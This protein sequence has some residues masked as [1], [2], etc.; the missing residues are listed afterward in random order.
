MPLRLYYQSHTEPQIPDSKHIHVVFR[1][2]IVRVSFVAAAG[3]V[4]ARV[5]TLAHSAGVVVS[6]GDATR[7][8]A[9]TSFP[10]A[11]A[12]FVAVIVATEALRELELGEVLVRVLF[13]LNRL[14]RS[15]R[16]VLFAFNT[17]FLSQPDRFS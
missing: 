10:P 11:P 6:R 5:A 3:F 14:S 4:A 13:I 9:E 8:P 17:R 1:C 16:P 15:P 2:F 12:T 7:A